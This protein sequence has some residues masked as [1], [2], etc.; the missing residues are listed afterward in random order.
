M[1]FH[2]VNESN[3]CYLAGLDSG[4]SLNIKAF[5]QVDFWGPFK[6]RPEYIRTKK[7]GNGTSALS[8]TQEEKKYNGIV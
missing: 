7:E 2:R 4:M 5:I 1:A 3:V 6:S 8:L